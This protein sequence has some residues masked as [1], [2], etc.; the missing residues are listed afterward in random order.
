MR[1]LASKEDMMLEGDAGGGRNYCVWKTER[2][3]S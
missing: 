1:S 3:R 2:D